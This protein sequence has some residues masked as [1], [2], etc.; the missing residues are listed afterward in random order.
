MVKYNTNGTLKLKMKEMTHL[1][2][3]NYLKLET[4]KDILTVGQ[5][6]PDAISEDAVKIAVEDSV[7]YQVGKK[8]LEKWKNSG[9]VWGVI[10]YILQGGI[11]DIDI[12]TFRALVHSPKYAPTILEN[13]KAIPID[14]IEELLLSHNSEIALA[15][16][17]WCEGK[18]IPE[19][20]IKKWQSFDC[21]APR[22]AAIYATIGKKLPADRP[23]LL[24]D[25]EREW[26]FRI[27]SD[28]VGADAVF[29]SFKQFPYPCSYVLEIWYN[30]SDSDCK[31]AGPLLMKIAAAR[32]GNVALIKKGLASY[33]WKTQQ[34]AAKAF[35]GKNVRL[36]TILEYSC[37][38]RFSKRLAA[39]Y[40]SAGRKDVPDRWITE[41]FTAAKD[42]ATAA[43]FA[44]HRSGFQPYRT[45]EIRG[46]VF[47]KC[48]NGVIV[49]ARIP[50]DAEI[51]GRSYDGQYRSNKAEIVGIIG[52]F[53]GDAIGISTYDKKTKYRVGDKIIVHDFD[54]S[55][56]TF[57]KG[58]H[59]F[60]TKEEAEAYKC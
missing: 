59:F 48:L 40:A 25:S 23:Q 29:K 47:K 50:D 27:M 22:I 7:Q 26:A 9:Y 13:F 8:T 36:N 44:A 1:L 11:E 60:L 54:F 24:R 2:T 20:T 32:S 28:P 56:D 42:I 35:V 49:V 38:D 15:A 45:V 30:N 10:A 46:E 55:I 4:I 5:Y 14:I 37:S 3:R 21:L 53:Y 57:A 6:S 51:R 52:D 34:E 18:T 12:E 19:E 58:F 43:R 16:A 17:R 41:G 33:N 39:M 31:Y